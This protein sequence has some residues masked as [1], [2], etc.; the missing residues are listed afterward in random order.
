[1]FH[2]ELMI[3]RANVLLIYPKPTGSI[4]YEDKSF[5]FSFLLNIT[6][7]LCQSKC[8]RHYKLYLER[9]YEMLPLVTNATLPLKPLLSRQRNQ[10]PSG[11]TVSWGCFPSLLL[12]MVLTAGS[13]Y[14]ETIS[15]PIYSIIPCWSI[16][17][18]PWG[19]SE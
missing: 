19:A 12:L 14:L 18:T 9:H 17:L 16:H 5:C 1:M 7:Y 2:L 10:F 15:L 3:S 13:F 6:G 4:I 8:L 11:N